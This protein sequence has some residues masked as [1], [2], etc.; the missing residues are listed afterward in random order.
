MGRV[1]VPTGK[2]G[3]HN[4]RAYAA[5]PNSSRIVEV[6]NMAT[7]AEFVE[8]MTW[9]ENAH[10]EALN[11]DAENP[12]RAAGVVA[13]L[14]PQCGWNRNLNLARRAYESGEATGT[15]GACC[16]KA[17][18]ILNG[19][20]WRETLGG[21]KVR[22]FAALISD[23][24]DPTTVCVDRHAFDVAVGRPTNDESRK[25]LTRKGVYESFAAAYRRAA[26]TISR[27]TGENVTPAQV[28]A[29]TWV[30]WRRFKGADRDW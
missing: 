14:S 19:K 25:A 27:E 23:P 2:R 26:A 6:W 30:V 18:E 15:I 11:L 29:V 28:Q 8:G 4:G 21:D 24:T 9:Y 7:H 22:A 3:E 13:A 12:D 16:R 5:R 17:T 10:N 20:D 1:I